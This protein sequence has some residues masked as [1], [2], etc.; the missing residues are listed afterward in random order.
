M[1]SV[2][3]QSQVPV[4]AAPYHRCVI[5]NHKICSMEAL[6]SPDF[7]SR[8]FA[9]ISAGWAILIALLILALWAGFRASRRG[10]SVQ[11]RKAD[12]KARLRLA[13]GQFRHLTKR[14]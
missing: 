4:A 1:G 12:K 9:A 3:K 6:F 8:Q 10:G 7:W 13:F 2:T 11:T 14:E 5:A